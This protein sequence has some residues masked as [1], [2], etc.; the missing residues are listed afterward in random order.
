MWTWRSAVVLGLLFIAAAAVY[1]LGS[2]FLDAAGTTLLFVAG[3][4]MAFG[5]ATLI[6][7]SRDL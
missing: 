1:W 4:A 7:G 2:H 6:A 3:I 5:F